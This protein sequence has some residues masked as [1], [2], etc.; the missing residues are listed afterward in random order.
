MLG[1]TD[2]VNSTPAKALGHTDYVNGTPA[3]T[4]GQTDYGNSTPAKALAKKT[5]NK[6]KSKDQGILT[7]PIAHQL[8]RWGILATSILGAY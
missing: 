6:H 8:N 2:Y 5:A 4:L 7:A 3:K 1:H